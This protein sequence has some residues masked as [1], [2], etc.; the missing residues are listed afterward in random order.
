M[1]LKYLPEWKDQLKASVVDHISDL[2]GHFKSPKCKVIDQHDVK[3]PSLNYMQIMFLSLQ[4]KLP[5]M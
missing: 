2:K 4:T 3:T 1:E 5:I